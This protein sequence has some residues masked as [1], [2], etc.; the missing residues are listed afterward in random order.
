MREIDEYSYVS[1][2]N[3]DQELDRT[4]EYIC[5][6]SYY[7]NEYEQ[8]HLHNTTRTIANTHQTT[9][10]TENILYSNITTTP[11]A[12]VYNSPI[13]THS[14]SRI[15]SIYDHNEILFDAISSCYD[16]VG[17]TKSLAVIP[18]YAQNCLSELFA[19]SVKQMTINFGPPR[20]LRTYKTIKSSNIFM[21]CFFL[22]KIHR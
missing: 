6:D 4:F 3:I 15:N 11:R 8:N 12:T 21:F 22:S 1:P 10:P 17:N 5:D 16:M 9:F 13:L 14:Y 20:F 2:S 19:V 18:V 7:N